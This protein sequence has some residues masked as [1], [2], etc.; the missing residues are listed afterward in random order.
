MSAKRTMRRFSRFAEMFVSSRGFELIL[1][2]REMIAQRD[3]R[4]DLALRELYAHA[5]RGSACG[6]QDLHGMCLN[7]I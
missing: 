1:L 4:R 7:F 6:R 3:N 5:I 2:A